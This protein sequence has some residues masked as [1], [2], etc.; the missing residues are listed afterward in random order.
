MLSFT[1]HRIFLIVGATDMRN[2]APRR[3]MWSSALTRGVTLPI[4]QL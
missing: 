2:Y 3:I 1:G 4:R